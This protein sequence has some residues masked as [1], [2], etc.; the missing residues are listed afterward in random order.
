MTMEGYNQAVYHT[1]SPGAPC[2]AGSPAQ[3]P[4]LH[5]TTPNQFPQAIHFQN[6]VHHQ[7]QNSS[8]V[9]HRTPITGVAKPVRPPSVVGQNKSES[10]PLSSFPP[11]IIGKNGPMAPGNHGR[12]VFVPCF[13]GK[14]SDHYNFVKKLGSGSFGTVYEASAKECIESTAPP[15]CSR[16]KTSHVAVKVFHMN[17]MENGQPVPSWREKALRAYQS[18]VEVLRSIDHPN[19]VNIYETF[20]LRDASNNIIECA[21]VMELCRGGDLLETVVQNPQGIPIDIARHVIWQINCAVR[22]MQSRG[23]VHRDLKLENIFFLHPVKPGADIEDTLKKII[24]KVG[25]FGSAVKINGTM[26]RSRGGSP[27]Y[28]PPEVWLGQGWNPRGDSWSFGVVSYATLVG[29]M[30]FPQ[31]SHVGEQAT[32]QLVTTG[33]ANYTRQTWQNLDPV[34]KDFIQRLLVISIDKRFSIQEA[35]NHPFFNPSR[36][37]PVQ[38]ASIRQSISAWRVL[39]PLSQLA[40]QAM[41]TVID[42]GD[43][44]EAFWLF[45]RL[46]KDGAGYSGSAQQVA[47]VFNQNGNNSDEFDVLDDVSYTGLIA[48]LLAQPHLWFRPSYANHPGVQNFAKSIIRSLSSSGHNGASFTAEDLNVWLPG[49]EKQLV[50]LARTVAFEESTMSDFDNHSEDLSHQSAQQNGPANHSPLPINELAVKRFLERLV[51]KVA[52]SIP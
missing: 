40:L 36:P 24:V 30:P 16:P 22:H 2:P 19:L 25:D 45:H 51:G 38:L 18:E 28:L 31:P 44:P 12:S 6:N 29:S 11:K 4:E 7:S 14:V 49:V 37:P 52:S 3:A 10:N 13:D 35:L 20:E 41:A 32:M 48:V 17:K 33:Q 34:A 39:D 9:Q 50:D 47:E 21:V 1:P 5:H 26:S 42:D 23:W 27:S 8:M 43:I 46:D 15:L